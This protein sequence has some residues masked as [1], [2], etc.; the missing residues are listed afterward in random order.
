LRRHYGYRT[1]G[2][3]GNPSHAE[4]AARRAEIVSNSK[5]N[6]SRAATASTSHNDHDQDPGLEIVNCFLDFYDDASADKFEALMHSY[7]GVRSLGGSWMVSAR[8]LTCG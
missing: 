4:G 2:I 6:P 8:W 7:L 5:R 1:I 3:E